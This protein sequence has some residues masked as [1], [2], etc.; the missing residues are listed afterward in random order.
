MYPA[1]LR[2]IKE[3]RVLEEIIQPEM[4][5]L[6]QFTQEVES[7]SLVT[8]SSE[9][10]LTLWESP[11]AIPKVGDKTQ[12]VDLILSKMLNNQPITEEWLKA[13][14]LSYA[15]SGVVSYSLETRKSKTYLSIHFTE[16]TNQPLDYI[17][18]ELR[19]LIP[20]HIILK[21]L[22]TPIDKTSLYTGAIYREYRKEILC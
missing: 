3:F 14:L 9:E 13:K 17:Y 7:S 12:R 8:T 10:A 5:L 19:K 6:S 18:R 11:L 1:F 21:L 15:S 20:A 4:D 2:E 16:V 22:N